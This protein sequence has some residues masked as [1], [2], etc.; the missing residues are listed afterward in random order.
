MSL[1]ATFNY[2]APSEAAEPPTDTHAPRISQHSQIKAHITREQKRCVPMFPCGK[3]PQ[4]LLFIT[5]TFTKKP[6]GDIRGC[7]T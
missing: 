6:R 3:P 5:M 4:Q 1:P 7:V 2:S